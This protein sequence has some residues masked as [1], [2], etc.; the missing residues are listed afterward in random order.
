MS[1]P[2]KISHFEQLKASG[3]LPSP[4]GAALAIIRLT[5]KEDLSLAE[6]ARVIKTDPAFVGRLVK[7]AN[8]VAIS[9]GRPIASVQEALM[10]VGLPA[11]RNMALGFSLL[12]NYRSGGCEHFDY[13]RY[14]SGSLVMAI[15]C[16]GLGRRL[17]C[18]SPDEMFC[19]GLLARIGELALATLF[20]REYSE[21]LVEG[22]ARDADELIAM[23][24][25]AFAMNHRE[26]TAAMLADWGLPV[27]YQ[28]VAY[29][30]EAPLG[31]AF[32][33]E[34]REAKILDALCLAHE[35]A[36]LCLADP[37]ARP[38]LMEHLSPVADRTGMAPEALDTFIEEVTREWTEWGKV[39]QVATQR[40]VEPV[41]AQ[42]GAAGTAK[43]TRPGEAPPCVPPASG[44]SMRVVVVERDAKVR[45]TLRGVLERAGHR[46]FESDDG[47]HGMELALE[48][49]PQM[50]L[51]DAHM[52]G[53]GGIALT[54]ALRQTRIGRSIY[55]LLLTSREDDERLIEAFENGVDDFVT[56]PIRSRVLAARLRAG[57]RVIR[58]QQEVERDREEI[59]RFAAELAVTN[60]RLQEVA[61]TDQL[62]G[63]RNRRYAIDRIAQ[64][65][66]ASMRSRRPLSCMVI[67]I[68]NFKQINDTYGHDVGDAVLR[69][70]ASAIKL[71]LR[72]Q[73]VVARTGGDEFLVLCPDTDLRAAMHCAERL[74]EAVHGARVSVSRLNL[75]VTISVGV[76]E[77]DASMPDAD[78][79][80]KRADQ[81]AYVAKAQ[82]RDQVATVQQRVAGAAEAASAVEPTDGGAVPQ[83]PP[84]ETANSK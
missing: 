24:R 5:R 9:P 57:H 32:G 48:V 34:S 37:A 84:R 74:R 1:P 70:A 58:L 25:K 73:D 20:P 3:D 16:Q 78:A 35:I 67:D 44:V 33:E 76:A 50:M 7:A 59:R 45:A 42:A 69:Q 47:R 53:V 36:Q 39:L 22:R 10:V 79:M 17:R 61:L 19:L 43:S 71:G 81:G 52:P 56:K 51:V 23:E 38:A 82:G 72:S 14:W 63:F 80:I 29:H 30:F 66:S 11:V 26:L 75:R 27:I 2:I 54:R 46:V 55:I 21:V 62:T 6:L 28:E 18:A 49:Q 8:G 64:E 83:V 41:H 4:K 40:F 15:V 12:S 13:E 60:R 65:W 31:A 68:D 77:R